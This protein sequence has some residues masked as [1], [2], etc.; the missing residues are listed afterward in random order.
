MHEERAEVQG[1]EGLNSADALEVHGRGRRDVLEQVVALLHQ[2]LLA[3]VGVE[4]R[5]RGEVGIVGEE[6]EDPSVRA[7]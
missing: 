3:L 7:S 5:G 6:R 1:Q 4:D 2:R